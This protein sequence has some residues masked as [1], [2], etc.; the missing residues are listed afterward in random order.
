MPRDESKTEFFLAV[1]SLCRVLI[2][3]ACRVKHEIEKGDKH[4]ILEMFWILAI[5]LQL[6]LERSDKIVVL[7][8][9]TI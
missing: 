5:L 4:E 7:L 8:N 2:N 3:E 9:K 6:Y 1:S